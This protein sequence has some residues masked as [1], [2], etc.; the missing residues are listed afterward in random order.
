MKSIGAE[1]EVDN[2]RVTMRIS[3]GKYIVT[4]NNNTYTFTSSKEAW[5]FIF[6]KH[7]EVA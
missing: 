5:E 4:I 2:M 1:D 3:Q 7:K 6:N